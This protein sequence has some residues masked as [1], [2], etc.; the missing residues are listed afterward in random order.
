MKIW[1][2]P[3]V[4]SILSSVADLSASLKKVFLPVCPSRNP[5]DYYRSKPNEPHERCNITDAF[6]LGINQIMAENPQSVMT[7]AFRRHLEE[8]NKK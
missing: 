2:R 3:S 8:Q 7:D 6:R 4:P 1:P 5:S